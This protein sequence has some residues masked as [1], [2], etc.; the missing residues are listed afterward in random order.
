MPITEAKVKVPLPD[1]LE[2]VAAEQGKTLAHAGEEW[3]LN[4][5]LPDHAE[6]S[7]SFFV[8]PTKGVW[9]C[10]GCQ[11]G[12]DVVELA[13]LLWGYEKRDS[14]IAAAELLMMFGHGLP[15]RPDAWFRRQER[16]RPVR[17]EMHR[18]GVRILRRRL[19]RV[20]EPMVLAVEDD[21]LR[22]DISREVWDALGRQAEDLYARRMG[23]G[24]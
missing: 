22:D 9:H 7:P 5:L 17:D 2:R 18:L 8:N 16:Q 4:C 6:K 12:G 21:A 19:Y 14:H 23:A 15:K 13:R 20:L 3:K 10:F 24:R 11:R 1:L